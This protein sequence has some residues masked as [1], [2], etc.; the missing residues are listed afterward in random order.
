MN[1]KG[2]TFLG[3]AKSMS[4]SIKGSAS[5]CGCSSRGLKPGDMRLPSFSVSL[6]VDLHSRATSSWVAFSF[7]LLSTPVMGRLLPL[8]IPSMSINVSQWCYTT[9][10]PPPLQTQWL[11]KK[12]RSRCSCLC[13]AAEPQLGG[14]ASHV[15]GFK[16]SPHVFI[17]SPGSRKSGKFF[18]WVCHCSRGCTQLSLL[19]PHPLPSRWPKQITWPSPTP[20]GQEY[21]SVNGRNGRKGKYLLCNHSNYHMALFFNAMIHNF[22][23]ASN[24]LSTAYLTAARMSSHHPVWCSWCVSPGILCL[25]PV[26]SS[27]RSPPGFL[28]LLWSWWFYDPSHFISIKCLFFF[29]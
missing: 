28:V 22:K 15:I 23:R 10:L 12:H 9:S 25:N 29:S 3:S 4:W 21:S 2:A 1:S 18:S 16:S 8:E 14:C 19:M 27:Q 13:T 17:L 24:G 7:V 5:L 26:T 6:G 20:M 11:K